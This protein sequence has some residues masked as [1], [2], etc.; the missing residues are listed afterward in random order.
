[1]TAT[2]NQTMQLTATRPAISFLDDYNTS[3]AGESALSVAAA[4]LVLVRSHERVCGFRE[5]IQIAPRGG[6]C[7]SAADGEVALLPSERGAGFARDQRCSRRRA[8]LS[9]IPTGAA[10]KQ[11]AV[12]SMVSWQRIICGATTSRRHSVQSSSTWLV[13]YTTVSY[14]HLT[15]PTTPYV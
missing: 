11:T 14:T 1:M 2:A 15:L 9:G 7:A 4:D 6:S 10:R 8:H 13:S 12:A 5:R 3:T